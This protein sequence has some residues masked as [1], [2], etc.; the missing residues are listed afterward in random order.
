MRMQVFSKKSRL[1]RNAIQLTIILNLLFF[2]VAGCI[3]KNKQITN[4]PSK[5]LVIKEAYTQKEIPGTPDRKPEVFLYLIAEESSE[6]VQL[7]SIFYCEKMYSLRKSGVY[8]KTKVEEGGNGQSNCSGSQTVLY[9]SQNKKGFNFM[10]KKVE[11]KE[12]IYLP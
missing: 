9:Y 11:K 1:E 5:G 6:E 3:T 2:L 7:D 8:S 4:L 12:P 10:I